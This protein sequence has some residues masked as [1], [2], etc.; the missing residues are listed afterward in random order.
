MKTKT[1]LVRMRLLPFLLALLLAVALATA[2]CSHRAATD[3]ASGDSTAQILA[4]P[5]APSFIKQ[6]AARQQQIGQTQAQAMS[7]AADHISR[8]TVQKK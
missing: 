1:Y 3:Q 2:G 7:A 6:Q 8:I 4:D 5:S